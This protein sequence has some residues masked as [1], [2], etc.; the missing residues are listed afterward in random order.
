MFLHRGLLVH[1]EEYNETLLTELHAAGLN[2]LGIH[3]AGGKKASDTLEEAIRLHAFPAGIKKNEMAHR[4]GIEVTYEA[5]ALRW[6][7]PGSLFGLVPQWFRMNEK[8]DRTPDFHM[9]VSNEE[10]VFYLENRSEALARQ[11]WTGSHRWSLWPDDVHGMGCRCP[12]CQKLT[13]SDQA[14]VIA[15]AVQRG[16]KRVDP[17]ARIS[18]LAYQ[19]TMEVPVK[20]QPEEG[21]FLE[22]A[23]I[24]RD[25][26]CPLDDASSEKNR[27]EIRNVR[28]LISFFGKSGAQALDY[29][30]DNS[31]FSQW[32]K[33]PR[34]FHL[35]TDILKRDAA[36]YDKIGFESITSFGC[37]LGEDY[38]RLYGKPPI[39]AYGQCLCA[40]I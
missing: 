27:K 17:N 16:V 7:L 8:G 3:P 37:F 22:F 32:Q 14:L 10:A 39:L 31:L 18:F 4:L 21:I 29:W 20:I 1:P 5:H 15:N 24:W 38:R 12:E 2:V 6:L 26:H 23:P 30:M 19:D 9:C 36:F 25:H 11:L 33:P 40:D 28:Q 34:P 35:E 13:V